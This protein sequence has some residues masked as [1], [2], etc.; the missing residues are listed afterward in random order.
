MQQRGGENLELV[1][2]DLLG[3]V[4]ERLQRVVA[5]DFVVDVVRQCRVQ[6]VD[7]AFVLHHHSVP[8]LAV[9]VMEQEGDRDQ[10]RPLDALLGHAARSSEAVRCPRIGPPRALLA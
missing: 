7:L 5:L 1:L 10:H 3:T 6:Q 9:A 2:G 4:E 8:V